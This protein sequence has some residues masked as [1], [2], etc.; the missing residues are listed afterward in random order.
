MGTLQLIT[1][2]ARYR[3]T[4]RV[5]PFARVVGVQSGTR[6]ED[7]KPVSLADSVDAEPYNMWYVKDSTSCM[8]LI[9]GY[10]PGRRRTKF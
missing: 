8:G 9:E 2:I 6:T 10:I 7:A 5:Q 4:D 3:D 1:W